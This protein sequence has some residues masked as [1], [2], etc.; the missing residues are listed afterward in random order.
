MPLLA[1]LSA[2]DELFL[3]RLLDGLVE[4]IDVK[5]FLCLLLVASGTAEPAASSPEASR[6]DGCS[7][8]AVDDLVMLDGRVEVRFRLAIPEPE[9][10]G[11]DMARL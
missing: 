10:D 9:E 1:A 11:D 5:S 8:S 7:K 6:D 3:G 2:A 4:S